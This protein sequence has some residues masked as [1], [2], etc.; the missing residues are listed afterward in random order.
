[1]DNFEDM[2][3]IDMEP[4]VDED[5]EDE[6]SKDDLEQ[7]MR[8]IG[9]KKTVP[10][11]SS[12]EKSKIIFT[13]CHQL[14]NGYKTTIPEIVKEKKLLSSFEIAIEEFDNG[15][16]PPYTLKRVYPDGRYELWSHDDFLFYPD[17]LP[18][19]IMKSNEI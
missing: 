9:I 15:K 5:L 3:E 1:M 14:N 13:R 11:M 7:E 17:K 2:V 19:K 10:V 4:E 18:Q 12:F 8:M 16:L 6:F